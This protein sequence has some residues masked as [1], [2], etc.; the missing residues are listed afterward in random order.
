MMGR[1][2]GGG[3]GKS[4]SLPAPNLPKYST[5]YTRDLAARTTDSQRS[6]ASAISGS[7]SP[8]VPGTDPESPTGSA[9]EKPP[10]PSGSAKTWVEP[11]HSTQT[12]LNWPAKATTRW[13][14]CSSLGHHQVPAH[15]G[16][17]PPCLA[18]PA[19]TQGHW[20]SGATGPAAPTWGSGD[21]SSHQKL[22]HILQW[23][24]VPPSPPS[25]RVLAALVE[26]QASSSSRGLETKA[27][28]G[29][30]SSIYH[31]MLP[32]SL[33]VSNPICKLIIKNPHNSCKRHTRQAS[34]AAVPGC[35]PRCKS[36]PQ[37]LRSFL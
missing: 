12:K 8:C 30:H 26:G 11:G 10:G 37:T 28:S 2:S 15:P 27:H 9:L 25:G 35:T 17:L 22:F 29:G 34:P 18:P 21:L 33:I 1:E 20:Q 3:K 19:A 13:P 32:S 7:G 36:H 16:P 24:N 23:E 5:V 31:K 4:L 14:R 6:G